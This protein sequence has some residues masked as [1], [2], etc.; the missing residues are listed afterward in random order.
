MIPNP[1][2]PFVSTIPDDA[3]DYL[4]WDVIHPTE[5]AYRIVAYRVCKTLDRQI[6]GFKPRCFKI[7]KDN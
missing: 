4:F 1:Q 5:K 7:L 6:P 3:E 2:P